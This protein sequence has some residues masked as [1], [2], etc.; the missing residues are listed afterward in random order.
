MKKM[1]SKSKIKDHSKCSLIL[2]H[3]LNQ[4]KLKEWDK[5]SLAR[6][7]QGRVVEQIARNMFPDAVLQD[8]K[9]N[10]E[11]VE[12]TKELLKLNKPIF[13]AAFLHRNTIIQFD[14]LIPNEEGT[15]DAVEVKS[16][17]SFKNDYELDTTVQYWIATKAGIKIRNFEVWFIN[18]QAE[19]VDKNYFSK[20]NVTSLVIDNLELFETELSKAEKTLELV[21]AP[22]VKQGSHCDKIDC[23]YRNTPQCKIEI[24]KNSVLAL[25]RFNKGW[26]A[27][28]SGILTVDQKEFATAYPNYAKTKSLI[29]TS[30]LEN[31]LVVNQEGIQSAI[32]QW[33]M[34]YNFFDFETLM[35][36]IP[37]LE[38]QKPY[39]Q[40]VFQFSNHI[41]RGDMKMEHQ[42]FLHDSLSNPD[43]EVIKHLLSFLNNEG[44]I[45]AYNKTFEETRVKDLAKKY[46]EYSDR[47]MALV[48]RFVDL[49]EVV[50]DNVYHPD[51]MG[52]Y[53]LKVVSPTL[54]KEFGSYSDSLIK[55]GSEIAKYYTEM[56]T[57]QDE[58]RKELI[59]K[60][61]FRY[62]QYDTLN[63]FLVLQFLLNQEVN[64]AEIVRVNLEVA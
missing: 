1:L 37:L 26:E 62:C 17:S 31:R 13:E 33:K 8:K 58:T 18:N 36:A 47:L 3:E 5:E 7:E 32:N 52:S 64:L 59:K 40:V 10:L 60:A 19:K 21:D 30:I 24:S 27:H 53:S 45:I 16:S 22:K 9:D 51:F 28:H 11:K 25:P 15:Y 6:F 14:V 4:P 61:L 50:K 38:K 49:M 46:P 39:E 12:M 42:M 35:S 34:P 2:W 55:S 43:Q 48:G 54:L 57:T 41:Y 29:M 44:S 20:Q 56:L 63:L 23:A